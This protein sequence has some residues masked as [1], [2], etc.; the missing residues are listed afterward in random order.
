M[1]CFAS[2]DVPC[3]RDPAP[4]VNPARSDGLVLKHWSRRALDDVTLENVTPPLQQDYD[5]ARY[6]IQIDGPQYTPEEYVAHLQD[7]DWSKEETDY[8]VS[9]VREY[10]QRWH[11]ILDR[12]DFQPA[13]STSPAKSRS[14]ED[15]KARYYHLLAACMALRTPG[16][17]ANMTASEFTLHQ[18]LMGYNAETETQRKK[19]ASALLARSADESKEEDHLLAELQRIMLAQSR[20]ETERNEIRARLEPPPVLQGGTATATAAAGGAGAAGGNQQWN[21]SAALGTLFQQLLTADKSKKRGRLS[22]NASDIIP[23]P[24]LPS[25]GG[26]PAA[27]STPATAGGGNHRDSVTGGSAAMKKSQSGAGATAS[28]PTSG[29]TKTLSA[30]QEA[31]FGVTTHERLTSGVTFKS[32][33]L[34]K[35]RQAKSNAQTSKMAAALAELGVPDMVALPT[36]RVTEAFEGMVGALGKLLDVRKVIEKEEGELK[37][38]EKMKGEVA[39]RGESGD[40]AAGGEGDGGVKVEGEGQEDGKVEDEE[41]ANGEGDVDMGEDAVEGAGGDGDADDEPDGDDGVEEEEEEDEEVEVED[42]DG[43][44]DGDG[45]GDADADTPDEIEAVPEA[46]AAVRGDSQHKRS[47]SVLSAASS[48][49]SKRPRR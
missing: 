24:A 49:S 41:D 42:G 7:P 15:M 29:P 46:A 17:L 48:Q 32:D 43:D 20:L 2:A 40:G 37:V 45:D 10:Y 25:A 36:A 3:C 4:F 19:L 30:R 33:R 39:Y 35:L 47:A 21:T 26:A 16:G 28:T 6:N 5:F 44:D 31:R 9:M 12:W 13:D 18:T 8:L 23:S 38:V 11:H 1:L 34:V 27:T 14:V 22:L